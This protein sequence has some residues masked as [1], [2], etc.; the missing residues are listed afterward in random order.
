MYSPAKKETTCLE[1]CIKGMD[2]RLIEFY[3]KNTGLLKCIKFIGRTKN[4]RIQHLLYFYNA[5][6]LAKG[7]S[8]LT[9]TPVLDARQFMNLMQNDTFK[10]FEAELKE[11]LISNQDLL[12][13]K[14]SPTQL[15][16]LDT[17][18]K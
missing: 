11:T 3:K 12:I 13:A 15:R 16:K 17:L 5:Y 8:I 6:F 14:L 10:L 4:E 2:K 7:L 18:I 1:Y 9:N